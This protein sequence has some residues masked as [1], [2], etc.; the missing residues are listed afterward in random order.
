[1]G[2]ADFFHSQTKFPLYMHL[3]ILILIICPH[4]DEAQRTISPEDF[5]NGIQ[6]SLFDAI[7]DVRTQNEWDSGHIPNATHMEN[8]QMMDLPPLPSMLDGNCNSRAMTVV[9]YCRSGN[10]ARSAIW[11][12]KDA[13]F[14]GTLLNGQG[15]SQWQGG[16]YNL[17]MTKSQNP[18]CSLV[19]EIDGLSTDEVEEETI[20]EETMEEDMDISDLTTLTPTVSPTQNPTQ[21]PS[22]IPSESP[23]FFPTGLET[24]PEPTTEFIDDHLVDAPT[25]AIYYEYPDLSANPTIMSTDES[26]DEEI[27]EP[28]AWFPFVHLC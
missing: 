26:S 21:S 5:Y 19:D 7:I 18:P 25:L 9:V 8:L 23:T 11:K 6:N 17:V 14:K 13:G 22:T 12:L 20:E 3:F 10:R 4:L 28:C 15:V 1:M 16:G 24:T 2:Q 27:E